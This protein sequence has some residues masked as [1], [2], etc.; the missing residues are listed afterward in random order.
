[1]GD[2]AK[3]ALAAPARVYPVPDHEVLETRVACAKIDLEPTSPVDTTPKITRPDLVPVIDIPLVSPSTT[4]TRTTTRSI[5]PSASATSATPTPTATQVSTPTAT[6]EPTPSPE[7]PTVTINK[8]NSG[9]Q[10]CYGPNE[11][12]GSAFTKPGNKPI[13]N[14]R[15]LLW[16]IVNPGGQRFP[17]GRGASGTFEVSPNQVPPD[18]NT[19]VF[20][21]TDPA[22]GLKTSVESEIVVAGC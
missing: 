5:P 8:P 11:F 21:A 16:E 10:V 2:P 18:N 4:P 14:A 22:S 9:D 13:T 20:T 3:S 1:M 15:H 12:A 7:R 6:P 17:L 19:V